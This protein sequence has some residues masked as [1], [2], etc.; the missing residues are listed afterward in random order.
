MDRTGYVRVRSGPSTLL[1]VHIPKTAGTTFRTILWNQYSEPPCN[2]Y[3][4]AW[5]AKAGLELLPRKGRFGAVIGHFPYGL[6][7]KPW[8]QPLLEDNVEYATFVRDPVRR[9]VSNFNH[10]MNSDHPAHRAIIAKHPTFESFLGHKWAHNAQTWFISG[11]KQAH[12]NAHRGPRSAPRSITWQ[13]DSKSSVSRS[14]STKR[15][16]SSRGRSAGA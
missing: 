11:W 3:P 2:L 15:S 5:E 6:H 8:I 4:S 1:V 13:S 16:S 14:A 12:R 9:V 7:S 10:L